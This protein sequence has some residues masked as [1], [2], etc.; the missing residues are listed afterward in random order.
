MHRSKTALALSL[1]ASS[2]LLATPASAD[3]KAA[4]VQAS[5][6]GQTLRDAH[7]LVEAREQFRA[8][9]RKQC[10]GVVQR[11]CTGWLS[12]VER[13]LPTIVVSAKN[14]S[15]GDLVDVAV[16]VD[17]AALTAKLDGQAVPMNP[18]PHTFHFEMADGTKLDQQVVVREGEKNQSVAVVIKPA[19]PVQAAVPAPAP[20]PA[21]A[22]EAKP[23][24][25]ATPDSGGGSGTWKTVGWIAGGVGVVGVAVGVVFGFAAMSDK[26]NAN[27]DSHNQCDSGP[28]SSARGAATASDIALIAGGVLAAGGLTLVLVAPGAHEATGTG[29][30]RVAPMVGAGGGGAVIGTSW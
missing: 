6:Q 9:S 16:S 13:S 30:V 1:C 24:T 11:D 19:A 18:G 21:P 4:C 23:A 22:P 2:L 3:D 10:P 29:S 17:G 25:V 7:K 20:A 15:G 27:C 5:S 8:C 14:A 28:L 12:D 26:N